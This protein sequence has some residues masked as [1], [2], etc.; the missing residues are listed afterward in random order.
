MY[1]ICMCVLYDCVYVCDCVCVCDYVC[2][3]Y[4]K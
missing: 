4:M 2:E 1:N 3:T